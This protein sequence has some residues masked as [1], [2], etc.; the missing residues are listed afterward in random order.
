MQKIFTTSIREL[1]FT[2]FITC[3][4]FSASATE[5]ITARGYW[6]DTTAQAT[7]EQAQ[8][9]QY[10]PFDGVLGRGYTQSATWIR[11]TI[12]PPADED[13]LV[14]RIRPVYLDE[15]TL[16]DP[17]DTTGKP[18]KVGDTTNYKDSEYK[19][20]SHTFEKHQYF[21]HRR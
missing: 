11:L 20:L 19:S 7:F 8:V 9:Q 3:L 15:I 12:T 13:E 14:L 21:A 6:E 17:L 5:H 10:T 18:R 1:V 4:G 2:L 16:Y